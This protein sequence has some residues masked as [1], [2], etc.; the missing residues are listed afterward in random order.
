M[1]YIRNIT[2]KAIE[3]DGKPLLVDKYMHSGKLWAGNWEDLGWYYTAELD[4][5]DQDGSIFSRVTNKPAYEATAFEY[6]TMV[7]HARNAFGMLADL[8]EPAGY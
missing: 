8:Q 5:M 7:C 6:A 2:D 4:F 3:F 1:R